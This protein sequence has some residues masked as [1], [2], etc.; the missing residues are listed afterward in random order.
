MYSYEVRNTMIKISN[1]LNIDIIEDHIDFYFILNKNRVG[2][3]YM[4]YLSSIK[5]N[6]E[7]WKNMCSLFTNQEIKLIEK[8]AA[9]SLFL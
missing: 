7:M 4:C 1:C 6:S 2:S 9:N 8:Y 5:N 3:D